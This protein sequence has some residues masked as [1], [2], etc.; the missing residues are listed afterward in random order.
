MASAESERKTGMP[1]IRLSEINAP[2]IASRRMAQAA[3]SA[4]ELV[5]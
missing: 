2:C 5:R 3:R 1:K 4:G